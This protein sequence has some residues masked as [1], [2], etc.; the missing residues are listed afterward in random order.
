MG[1]RHGAYAV[2]EGGNGERS[3][4]MNYHYG[5]A[6]HGRSGVN[7]SM[8][9]AVDLTKRSPWGNDAYGILPQKW[10]LYPVFNEG[11]FSPCDGEVRAVSDEWPNEI[12]WGGKGPYNLGNYVLIQMGDVYVLI[13]HLQ[14]GSIRVNAGSLV[15]VG[16]PIAQ[17]GNSGWTSQPHV[18][19]QAMKISQDSFWKGEGLPVEFDG[20]NPVKNALFFK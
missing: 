18:H 16:D 20:Q 11:I 14:K 9:Y 3:S 19:I 15:K 12:P 5:S 2:F 8:K 4:L 1:L 7:N 10:E 6:S 13:G 17:V